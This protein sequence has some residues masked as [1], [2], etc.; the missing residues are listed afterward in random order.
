M[1]MPS[2]ATRFLA[3]PEELRG[4]RM[5]GLLGAGAMGAVYRATVIGGRRGL[6]SGDEVAL[7]VLDPSFAPD[8]QIVRRF[9]R[10]AGVGLGAGHPGIARVYEIGSLRLGEDRRV[11]YIVQELLTGGSLQSR[12]ELEGPQPEPVVREVGRQVA[13]TLAFVHGRN[14]VHRDL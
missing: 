8:A 11:H 5:R 13:E 4:Y 9:K 7:K 12:L 2:P 10:E 3:L 1:V 14:I 6:R